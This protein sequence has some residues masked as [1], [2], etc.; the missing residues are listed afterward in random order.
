MNKFIR[1]IWTTMSYCPLFLVVAI[2]LTVDYTTTKTISANATLMIVFWVVTVFSCVGSIALLILAKKIVAPTQINVLN[3]SS[4]DTELMGSL[5]AYLLPMLTLVVEDVNNI[6]LICFLV[7]IAIMLFITKAV[8][9]NPIIFFIGYKYY[10]IQTSS[11]MTYTLITRQKR[12]NPT[13]VKAVI[14]IFPEIYLE[15]NNV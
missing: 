14:E 4:K 9:I 12:F 3:A 8:Y 15:V 11:G 7:I 13:A 1:I 6:A 2:L 10:S 5:T